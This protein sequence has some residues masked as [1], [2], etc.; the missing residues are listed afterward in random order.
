MSLH[1]LSSSRRMRSFWRCMSATW[2]GVERGASRFS[3]W[4]MMRQALRS[5]P[6]MFLNAMESRLR[7]SR[8]S[9]SSGELMRLLIWVTTSALISPALRTRVAAGGLTLISFCLVCQLCQIK[10]V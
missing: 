6:V 1:V 3:S 4:S 2:C 9:W 10:C 5:V 7:S 8:V